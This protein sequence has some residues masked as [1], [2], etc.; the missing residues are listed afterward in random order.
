MIYFISK[1]SREELYK[2]GGSEKGYRVG[3]IR[4]GTPYYIVIKILTIL[5]SSIFKRY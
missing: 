2:F 4:G 3:L 5:N 1:K